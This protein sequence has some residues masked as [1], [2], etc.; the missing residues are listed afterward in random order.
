MLVD[1]SNFNV[2]GKEVEEALDEAGI[3]VNKNAVPY[4][5]KPP[6][7]TSGVRLGTPS[8]T[9]RGMGLAEMDEI[10]DIIAAIVRNIDNSTLIAEMR[11][12]V[13]VLCDRFPIYPR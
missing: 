2:T 11:K 9:T 4:D 7:I 13:K 12:R 3:T 5:D 10:A 8:V 6:T 1:L